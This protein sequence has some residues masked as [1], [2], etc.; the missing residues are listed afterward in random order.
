M[1]RDTPPLAF[2]GCGPIDVSEVM[3]SRKHMNRISSALLAAAIG[4][5]SAAEHPLDPLSFDEH[6][7]VLQIL[8]DAGKLDP[9]TTF[10]GVHLYEPDKAAVL[11]WTAGAPMPRQAKAVVRNGE[12]AFEAVVDLA[13][14]RLESYAK[15]E[16]VQPYFTSGEGRKALDN[17]LEHPDF[18]AAIKRR[19][20]DD[21]TFLNCSI[22][23][24][25]YFGTDEQRGRRVGHGSCRDVRGVRNG[26]VRGL[27]GLDVVVDMKTNEVI[28][29]VDEGVVPIPETKADF[30]RT[31]TPAP[32][33]VPSPIAVTQ[34]GGPGYD[35]DGHWISWQNWRFHLRA[36]QRVGPVLSLVT[37]EDGDD[38]RSVLYQASL[39]EIFVPYSDPSFHWYHRN[40]IDAGE[41]AASGLMK[42]LVPGADCPAYASYFSALISDQ[43]GHPET[44]P[45]I[46][47]VFERESGDPSWRH[48]S[49]ELDIALK[50]DLVIRSVAVIGNYDYI[51][52]WVLHQD[53]SIHVG[54]GATG[55]VE[56]KT[57][58]SRDARS[59]TDDDAYGRFVDDHI[60]GVN[61][62]HYFAFRLDLDVDGTRNN[63]VVDRLV[64]EIL[65]PESPRRSVWKREAWQPSTELEARLK[66]HHDAPALWRFLSTSRT[67][68]LG[69]PTSYQIRPGM[70][71]G[72]LLSEDDY[73]RRRAGFIDYHL[74]VTPYD[75]DELY[76]AGD[77]PTLSEPGMGLP[78]WTKANR[79]IVGKDVVAWYTVGMHHLV[80][81]EDWPVMPVL[82]H[83]FEI[84]P[85]DFFDRNPALDLPRPH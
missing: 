80:R 20:Y 47:C 62:D 85:F 57:V 51:F 2:A 84:R 35:V 18:V 6:W 63:F 44:R 9:D 49:G 7:D 14:G 25:G 74:W 34:P 36:D 55:I 29:V 52:D 8:Y 67:T 23:P 26:W 60:V 3:M 66:I 82:W 40:F 10:S 11:A 56:A 31:S 71:A 21:T 32:R 5:A 70:T 64:T 16:G 12:D 41:F 19:G 33:D 13:H 69:Y 75:R 42:P 72:V 81:A 38:V 24:P 53:G 4:T 27:A 39:S 15:L 83:W 61:H 45:N 78:A 22:G 59:G 17:M 77:Y 1:R 50:R 28:R 43:S 48:R 76:A 46:Y 37:Y 73:P 65:P 58:K 68:R 54:V 30:D 79:D